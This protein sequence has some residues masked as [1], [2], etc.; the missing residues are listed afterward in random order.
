MT[1][2]AC[3]KCLAVKSL[4]DFPRQRAGRHGR[5]ASCKACNADDRRAR[6]AAN[7]EAHGE[8]VKAYRAL[9]PERWRAYRKKWGDE[10]KARIDMLARQ[11]W[12]RRKY[13]LTHDD[14][15]TMLNAQ[16]NRCAICDGADPGR[17]NSRRF[18]VDHDHETGRVRG[19][20]CYQCNTLLSNASDSVRVLLAAERYL[21]SHR[22]HRPPVSPSP[23]DA[24]GHFSEAH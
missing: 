24:G 5:A 15:V 10:N 3:S 21:Q 14:Y 6:Y 13:G 16:D 18:L 17:K 11:G 1:N 19:L 20:L 12:L 2:K 23:S 7:K 4:D 22:S 9:D 8:R